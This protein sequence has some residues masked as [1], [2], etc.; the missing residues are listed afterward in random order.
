MTCAEVYRNQ[1]KSWGILDRTTTDIWNN[2]KVGDIKLFVNNFNKY[3]NL[4]TNYLN[5]TL[6]LIWLMKRYIFLTDTLLFFT[7]NLYR[8]NRDPLLSIAA[9]ISNGP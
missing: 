2:K 1:Q 5:Q 7:S 3:R 4:N 8:R 9:I 6:A